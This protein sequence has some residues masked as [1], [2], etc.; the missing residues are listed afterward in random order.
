MV[1]ADLWELYRQMLR[2]RVFEESVRE[3]WEAGKISGEMHLG[4]GEEA[5]VA[6]VVCQL[7]DGDA[8]ALDHRGTPAMIMRGVDPVLLLREFLG[9]P[10]GLCGGMG[11]HMHLFSKEHLA[12]SSGIVG[13][14]GPA[15]VGFALA[16]EHLRPGRVAVAFFG[17]G[18]TNQGMMLEAMNLAAAWKLPVIF[19][20]KDNE[21]SISTS[22][23]DVTASRVEARAQ[24]LGLDAIQV[25]GN[26][27]EAV[28]SIAGEAL[29]RARQGNGPSFLHAQCARLE[30]HFL[31]DLLIRA[32]RRP[33]AELPPIAGPL[34]RS[35]ARSEGAH[36]GERL[37]GISDL[38]SVIWNAR[39]KDRSS[40]EDPILI[41]R[42]KLKGDAA[43]LRDLEEEVRREMRG[44]RRNA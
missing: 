13:A 19:V 6:G 21:W 1:E 9:H 27:V 17:E 4:M 14:S 44:V 5:V 16:A 42:E 22:S 24:G 35:L 23:A 41:T 8:L 15:G 18:A 3:L 30:G 28:W 32:G 43:R 11:G 20:C 10:D 33:W 40:Q 31:G 38:L 34:I 29:H 37:K 25:D 12:A 26:N 39:A 36:L 2:S 7:Q